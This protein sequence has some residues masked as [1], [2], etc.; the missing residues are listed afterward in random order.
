MAAYSLSLRRSEML[1][2]E[3][4][5]PGSTLRRTHLEACCC[6]CP[7]TAT[8]DTNSRF[9]W[10][11]LPLPSSSGRNLLTIRKRRAPGPFRRSRHDPGRRART[12]GSRGRIR[13]EPNLGCRPP[14][15]NWL[16]FAVFA[17]GLVFRDRD[18]KTIR[19]TPVDFWAA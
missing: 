2:I 9:F 19:E 16:W 17:S 7:D 1:A 8:S 10:G 6:R 4:A 13:Q 14:L 18:I 3:L 11:F 12:F 5:A 15:W